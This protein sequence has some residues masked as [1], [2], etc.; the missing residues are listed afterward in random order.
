[1]PVC[2]SDDFVYGF[3]AV[4][5]GTNSKLFYGFSLACFS[6]EF[7]VFTFLTDFCFRIPF[8]YHCWVY[9]CPSEQALLVL[10]FAA[11]ATT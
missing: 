2:I 6:G 5:L 7:V 8:D 1:M 11:K 3:Y 9:S 4:V 10:F